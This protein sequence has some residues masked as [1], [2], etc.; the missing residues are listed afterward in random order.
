MAILAVTITSCSYGPSPVKQPGINASSA[1]SQAMEM[2]DKNGDGNVSGDELAGAP[3]LNA[4]VVR[5]DTNN[6]K[7]VSADEVAARANAWKGMETGMTTVR[8]HITLDGQPLSG[9]QVVFEP[10][11]FLGD[12]IKIAK[13]TTN[14]FGDVAPT[15]AVED[16]PDPKSPGGVHFGL[17]KVRISKQANGKETIPGRYNSETMLGQEVSYDD[18]GILNNNL[19]IA[20]KSGA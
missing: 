15:I 5:L 13:G 11:A 3:S 18:P 14:Q 10:E 16:R 2:Y 17:Y 1:G 8:C 6:D 9:A 7:G 4:A 19:A 20:L 12:E